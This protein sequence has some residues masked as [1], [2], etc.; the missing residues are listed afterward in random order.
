MSLNILNYWYDDRIYKLHLGNNYSSSPVGLWVNN[1]WGQRLL[2]KSQGN[3]P[4]FAGSSKLRTVSFHVPLFYDPMYN[5]SI[6]YHLPILQS[7]SQSFHNLLLF[8]ISSN[9]LLHLQ[10]CF[11]LP[12]LF[13]STHPIACVWDFLRAYLVHYK[14]IVL[15]FT[16]TNAIKCLSHPDTNY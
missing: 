11:Y 4:R 9:H 7:I 10:N 8:T 14:S 16:E 5:L 13:G 12:T 3:S 2:R 1:P 6:F 15:I